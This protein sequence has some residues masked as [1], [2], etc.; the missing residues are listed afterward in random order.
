MCFKAPNKVAGVASITEEILHGDEFA[1]E[2]PFVKIA[3]VP[4]V[5]KS[6]IF[7]FMKSE[8]KGFAQLG[9]EW[10]AAFPFVHHF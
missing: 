1:L 4:D 10:C 7:P 2:L 6:S 3:S 8:V 5:W 9:K